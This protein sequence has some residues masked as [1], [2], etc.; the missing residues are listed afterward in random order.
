MRPDK[1][2]APDA[3][4]T[5]DTRL[6]VMKKQSGT[7]SQKLLTCKNGRRVRNTWQH[8]VDNLKEGETAILYEGIYKFD[9]LKLNKAIIKQMCYDDFHS[10]PDRLLETMND[11]SDGTYNTA[12]CANDNSWSV[13]INT[14]DENKMIE[15]QTEIIKYINCNDFNIY[16]TPN[17]YQIVFNTDTCQ[18]EIMQILREYYYLPNLE[19]FLPIAW[20]TKQ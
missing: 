18:Y 4:D 1:L 9:L 10:T 12:R 13:P 3:P 6:Y 14:L 7:R 20:Q 19:L 2:Y 8:F 16:Q 15:I 11:W 5:H 17:G